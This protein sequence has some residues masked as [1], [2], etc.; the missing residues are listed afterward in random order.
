MTY[1]L[2]LLPMD[3]ADGDSDRRGGGGSGRL[4]REIDRNLITLIHLSGI[5]EGETT[6]FH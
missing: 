3:S 1:I 6:A 4:F 5:E 2:E